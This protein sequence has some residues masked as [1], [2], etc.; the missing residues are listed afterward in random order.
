[1]FEKGLMD[2]GDAEE[3]KSEERDIFGILGWV[4]FGPNANLQIMY[5]LY[6]FMIHNECD[7]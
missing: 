4:E 6:N 7:T 1:M 3:R 2:N 5:V